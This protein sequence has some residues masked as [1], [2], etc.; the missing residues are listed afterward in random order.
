M[1]VYIRGMEMPKNCE[2]C[3]I[4]CRAGVK[5]NGFGF[6]EDKRADD[7]PLVEIKTPHGRLIDGDALHKLFMEYAKT[8]GDKSAS[9][10]FLFCAN[11]I[12]IVKPI[13]D[14]EGEVKNENTSTV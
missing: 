13:A 2:E 12:K 5:F 8:S 6:L 4:L 7:C 1:S 11:V 3:P 9:W 10:A 14:A